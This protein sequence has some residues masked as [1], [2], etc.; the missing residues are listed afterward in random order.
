MSKPEIPLRWPS[1]KMAAFLAGEKL[2]LMPS[3]MM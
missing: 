1:R 2:T 3:S